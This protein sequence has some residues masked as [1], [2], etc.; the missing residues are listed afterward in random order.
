MSLRFSKQKRK[1][2]VIHCDVKILESWLE[3]RK[4]DGLSTQNAERK[5][6]NPLLLIPENKPKSIDAKKTLW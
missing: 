3:Q 2:P 1:N 5:P 6:T 4:K